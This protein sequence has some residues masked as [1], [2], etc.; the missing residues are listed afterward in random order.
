MLINIA[1]VIGL[2]LYAVGWWGVTVRATTG[3]WARSRIEG[4]LLAVMLISAAFSTFK[5]LL[6]W[7]Q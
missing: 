4:A 7:W 6:G 1:I 5:S 2:A 3:A